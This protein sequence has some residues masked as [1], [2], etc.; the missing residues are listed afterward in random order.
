MPLEEIIAGERRTL[1][2]YVRSNGENQVEEYV[3]GLEVRDR[4]KVTALLQQAARRGDLRNWEKSRRINEEF[5]EF[6]PTGQVRIFW[7]YAPGNCMVL[8][9]GFTKKSNRTPTKEMEAGR[10]RYREVASEISH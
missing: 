10:R 7:C 3:E 8:F 5:F 9:Y 2:A 4:K 6:K 1:L